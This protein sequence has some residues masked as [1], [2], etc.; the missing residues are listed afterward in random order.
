[1]EPCGSIALCECFCPQQVNELIEELDEIDSN[2]A[3]QGPEHIHANEVILTIAASN[4]V[5][6]FLREATKKRDFQVRCRMDGGSERLPGALSDGRT[7]GEAPRCA[8]RRRC[9][10]GGQTV[11]RIAAL[12][13]MACLPFR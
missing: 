10:T 13:R 8:H 9:G 3:L 6:L 11:M 2:I 12:E 1:V 7:L 4:T 5:L